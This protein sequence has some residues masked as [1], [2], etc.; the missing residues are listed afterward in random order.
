MTEN[1]VI[2]LVRGLAPRICEIVAEAV[3]PLSTRIAEV[4]ARPIEKGEP[5]ER[6]PPGESG[7]QGPKGDSGELAALPPELATQI[8]S[9]VRLLHESPPLAERKETPQPSP[10]VARIERDEHGNF[11][12]I[13]DEPQA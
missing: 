4:E 11:V 10:R 8:A 1:E 7:P 13:Y 9:A 3:K 6:G 2:S 12:P 5:G